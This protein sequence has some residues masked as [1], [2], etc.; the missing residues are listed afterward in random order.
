[1]THG[2][3]IR[4]MDDEALATLFTVMLSEGDHIFMQKLKEQGIDATLIELPLES[5]Q[6]HLDWL[7]EDDGD[8]CSTGKAPAS[9]L[10]RLQT[11]GWA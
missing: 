3:E 9:E 8:V 11:V 5:W 2:D 6:S 4:S 7:K 10:P 1:M